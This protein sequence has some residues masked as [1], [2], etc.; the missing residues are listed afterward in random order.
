ML[1][2]RQVPFLTE[3]QL[4]P[5]LGQAFYSDALKLT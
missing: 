4:C 1:S 3:S 2:V 5:S